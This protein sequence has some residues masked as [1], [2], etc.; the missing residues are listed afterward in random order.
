MKRAKGTDNIGRRKIGHG[1]KELTNTEKQLN[2]T[3]KKQNAQVQKEKDRKLIKL[4][5]K[6]QEII[7]KQAAI[8]KI[9]S[10]SKNQ[11]L[12]VEAAKQQFF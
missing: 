3:E 11:T 6:I 5:Y 10:K 9:L 8:C 12:A 1:D 7:K 4:Q 2:Y